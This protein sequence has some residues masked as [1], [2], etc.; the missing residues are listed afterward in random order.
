MCS[1]KYQRDAVDSQ[2][3]NFNNALKGKRQET[4]DDIVLNQEQPEIVEELD[5]HRNSHV[6]DHALGSI[7]RKH[8]ERTF[9]IVMD[10]LYMNDGLMYIGTPI[11]T[12]SILAE[13]SNGLALKDD[14]GT[15]G[16]TILDGGRISTY[17]VQAKDSNGLVL[18]EDSGS[19]GIDIEDN[20]DIILYTGAVGIATGSPTHMLEVSGDIE[21]STNPRVHL[22][23]H[24]A[25]TLATASTHHTVQWDT[26]VFDTDTLY[27][28]VN[29]R[30]TLERDGYYFVSATIMMNSQAWAAGDVCILSAVVNGST[31]HRLDRYTA[32]SNGTRYVFLS[33]TVL[34]YGEV[35]DYITI[36]VY[37][38]ASNPRTVF[39]DSSGNYNRVCVHKVI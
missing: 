35:D 17:W 23:R 29:Y 5:N 34:L 30:I 11:V 21:V 33:G 19:Y 2:V 10:S 1:K 37:Y 6:L 3:E 22:Q 8:L 9:R 27:S 31:Q 13:D 15:L 25:Q 7:Q 26:T 18:S 24:A 38:V 4:V 39:A 14:S 20:G 32:E 16:L 28:G 36:T 12:S